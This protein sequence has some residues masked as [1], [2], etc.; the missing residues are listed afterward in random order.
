M[1]EEEIIPT[2]VETDGGETA[3]ISAD[4]MSCVDES[5]VDESA[6]DEIDVDEIDN[7]AIDNDAPHDRTDE[8]IKENASLRCR[9]FCLENHIPAELAN[10]VMLLAAAEAERDDVSLEAAAKSVW[11]R[12]SRIGDCIGSIVTDGK[13]QGRKPITTGAAVKGSGSKGAD[14]LRAAFGLKG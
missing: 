10:D 7:D 2:E 1:N 8:L 6:V 5:D 14:P 9:L 13:K 3:E 4:N 11:E 12:L